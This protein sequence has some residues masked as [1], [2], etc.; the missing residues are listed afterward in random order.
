M[1]VIEKFPLP[2]IM[3]I[4]IKFPNKEIPI[5]YK[6]YSKAW[7]TAKIFEEMLRAWDVRLGQNGRRVLLCLDNFCAHSSDLQLDNIHLAGLPSTQHDSQF[8][9]NGSRNYRE[10]QVPPQKDSAVSPA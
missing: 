3:E 8:S 9:T 2:A 4:P 5:K 1:N 7:M 6:A 10:P